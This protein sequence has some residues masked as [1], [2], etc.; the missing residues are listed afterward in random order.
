MTSR[1]FQVSH[2]AWKQSKEIATI[3]KKSTFWRLNIY[4]DMLLCFFKYRMWTN[5]Y[6]KVNFYNLSPSDR[7]RIGKEYKELGLKRDTW[8]ED[9]RENRKFL[10]K[11]ANIK[12]EKASL[13]EKRNKAYTN[14]YH[15]G[16]DLFVEYDVIIC[17]QHY[18]DGTISIGNG[19]RFAKHVFIDYS[20]DLILH[21]YVGLSDGVNIE[22]H[23]HQSFTGLLKDNDARGEKLEIYES[24]S[25]G[26]KSL[27][28]ESC[29]KIGRFAKIGA[30]AVV[31]GNIPPYA[32]VIGNPARIIGFMFTPQEMAEFEEKRYAP[33][34]RTP[35]EK[36][37]HYYQKYYKERLKDLKNYIKL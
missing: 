26:S 9:F 8:Q 35:I 10:I 23:S 18:L 16:K 6:L 24:V 36:Y 11:Y 5:Q 12:Y 3:E 19:V 17:R 4:L 21:D 22:T 1:F 34:E 30:G 13:R 27:I 37:N 32:I 29:H 31:R 20:G 7:K 2:Y 28:T 14:R 33:E 15:A 25:I